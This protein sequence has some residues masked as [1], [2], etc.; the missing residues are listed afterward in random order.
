MQILLKDDIKKQFQKIVLKW[1]EGNLIEYPWRKNRN[2][3][4]VLICEILLIRTKAPQV[5]PVYIEFM[6]M[7][8]TLENF[9]KLN[10]DVIENLIKSLGLAFRANMIA[11]IAFDIK[12]RFRNRIPDSISELKSLKGIGDYGANAILCFGFNQKKPLLD[13][14]FIRIFK[15]VFDIR[16]KTKTAKSDRFLWEFSENLLPK[17]DFIKYNYAILDLGGNI[18]ISKSPKCEICPLNHLCRYYNTKS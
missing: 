7:Y 10:R 14:N 17:K 6:K 8:P 4:R 9:L 16:S 3:Y 11:E 15:R 18:C 2:P 12:N 5:V 1:A 13:S